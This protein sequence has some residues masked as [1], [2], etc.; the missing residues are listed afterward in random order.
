MGLEYLKCST[1]ISCRGHRNNLN[2]ILRI[3]LKTQTDFIQKQHK[4]MKIQNKDGF[5]R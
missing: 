2:L 4:K 1:N 5:Y 3:Q